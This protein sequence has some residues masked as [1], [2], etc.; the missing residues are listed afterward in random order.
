V[1]PIPGY[2]FNF[3]GKLAKI[4]SANGG[5]VRVDFNNPL[6]GKTVIYSLNVKRVVSDLN[7]KIKSLNEFLFQR[8][9]SF[10]LEEIN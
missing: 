7:E 10:K 8:E 1:R 4:L 5:R 2:V 6:A 3:D 9:F